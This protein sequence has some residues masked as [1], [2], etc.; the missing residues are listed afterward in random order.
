[1]RTCGKIRDCAAIA[2]KDKGG[3]YI[4]CGY[5]EADEPLDVKEIKAYLKERLPYY[6]VPTALFQMDELPRNLNN[7]IDRK[8]IKPPKELDDHK[9]LE[10]LY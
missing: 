3:T 5:F 8:A 1:M 10:K 9:L 7:K 2:F 6:M 4:L